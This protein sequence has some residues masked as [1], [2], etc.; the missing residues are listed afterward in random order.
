MKKKKNEERINQRME[1]MCKK[2]HLYI[3]LYKNV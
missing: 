1:V 2:W 3:H